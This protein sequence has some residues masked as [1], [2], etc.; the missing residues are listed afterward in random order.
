MYIHTFIQEKKLGLN[1][2]TF[3]F[4]FQVRTYVGHR[5]YSRLV[6][7][8]SHSS[9]ESVLFCNEHQIECFSS[10]QPHETAAQWKQRCDTVNYLIILI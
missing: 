1:T 2:C 3:H 10:Q 6:N 4:F 9:K 8:I 7:T 5:S